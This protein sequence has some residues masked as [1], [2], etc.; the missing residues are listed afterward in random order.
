VT[1]GVAVAAIGAVGLITSTWLN[2]R[3]T[4][5]KVA[6]VAAQMKP[7]GGSSIRD[8][9]NRIEDRLDVVHKAQVA[10]DARLDRHMADCA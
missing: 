10:T 6:E 3:K 9:L 4:R 8:S 5:A 7:N 1:E 2:S